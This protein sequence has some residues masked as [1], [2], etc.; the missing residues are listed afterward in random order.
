[1]ILDTRIDEILNRST[2]KKILIYGTGVW[3]KRIQRFIEA[4]GKSI[5]GFVDSFCDKNDNK[6]PIFAVNKLDNLKKGTYVVIIGAGRSNTIKEMKHELEMRGL[7]E[8]EDFFL[9]AGELENQKEWNCIDI[10]LGHSRQIKGGGGK[11]VFAF[12]QV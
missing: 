11:E 7:C 5:D 1:M 3:G 6:Y 10:Y 2:G 4:K 8:E 12:I 9:P